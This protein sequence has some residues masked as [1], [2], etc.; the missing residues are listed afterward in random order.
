MKDQLALDFKVLIFVNKK[1]HLSSILALIKEECGVYCAESY[2][3][4]R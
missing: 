2:G 4:P 3:D 1:E